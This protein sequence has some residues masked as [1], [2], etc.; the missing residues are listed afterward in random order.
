MDAGHHIVYAHYRSTVVVR[1]GGVSAS[2]A[3]DFLNAGS[4][5]AALELHALDGRKEAAEPAGSGRC[6][7]CSLEQ[8]GPPSLAASDLV[9]SQARANL[10]LHRPYAF[11]D[12]SLYGRSGGPA[13][14]HHFAF[15]RVKLEAELQLC[16]IPQLFARGVRDLEK[17]LPRPHDIDRV[18]VSSTNLLVIHPCTLSSAFAMA[19]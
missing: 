3:L 2:K 9:S 15:R 18:V 17:L 19:A 11:V 7:P 14:R 13:R 4:H 1:W 5:H 10:G 8:L 12:A 6:I 16:Y